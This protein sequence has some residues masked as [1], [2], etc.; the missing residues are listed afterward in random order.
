MTSYKDDV[1]SVI[2]QAEIKQSQC[3]YVLL[4]GNQ[5]SK[6]LEITNLRLSLRITDIWYNLLICVYQGINKTIS[7]CSEH[8]SRCLIT[9]FDKGYLDLLSFL[10]SI[11]LYANCYI[12]NNKKLEICDLAFYENS[13]NP[14]LF[15]KQ[16]SLCKTN[17]CQSILCHIFFTSMVRA[18]IFLGMQ[19]FV[20][21]FLRPVK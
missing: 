6:L 4:Q 16:N 5:F 3:F 21:K 19:I 13:D 20:T 1:N 7:I 18:T 17:I 2:R 8:F 11:V 10:L 15:N 9:K 12:K 14:K